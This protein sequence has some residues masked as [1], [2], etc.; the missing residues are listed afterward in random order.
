MNE[1]PHATTLSI[2][3]ETKLRNTAAYLGAHHA[4]VE[5]RCIDSHSESQFET[6]AQRR[7]RKVQIE[8][9]SQTRNGC[10]TLSP[11]PASGGGRSPLCWGYKN[12]GNSGLLSEAASCPG[13]IETVCLSTRRDLSQDFKSDFIFAGF[14]C[15]LDDGRPMLSRDAA[16]P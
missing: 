5:L 3:L 15:Q 9:G 8:L 16:G 11:Q 14:T 1:L 13:L 12:N 4:S 2:E 7:S 6:E 10:H